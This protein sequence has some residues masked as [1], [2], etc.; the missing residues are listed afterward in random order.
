MSAPL[1]RKVLLIGCDSDVL[2]LVKIILTRQGNYE[3]VSTESGHHGLT[4]AGKELPDLI[5]IQ[6]MMR[7]MIGYDVCTQLK[8]SPTISRVPVLL[9]GALASEKAYPPA[10]ACGAA[11]YLEQPYPPQALVAACEAVLR[12][13]TYYPS[14]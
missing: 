4:L 14:L 8:Q 2:Q 12:D 13:G 7:D 11:G 6:I 5:I 9:H 1:M 3:F 10:Q